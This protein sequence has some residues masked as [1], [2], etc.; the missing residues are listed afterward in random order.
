[1]AMWLDQI[2]EYKI[3]SDSEYAILLSPQF[4]VVL[5]NHTSRDFLLSEYT[6]EELTFDQCADLYTMLSQPDHL[7]VEPSARFTPAPNQIIDSDTFKLDIGAYSQQLKSVFSAET[8]DEKKKSLEALANNLFRS[9]PFLACKYSNLRTA[10]SEIDIVVQFLGF[11][12]STIFDEFGRYFLVECKNWNT[13]V[14]AAQVRDFIG[15]IQKTRVKLGIV[16]AKN[17]ISGERDGADAVREIH[18]AFDKDGL[19]VIVKSEKDLR[20]IEMGM[21]FYDILDQKINKLRFDL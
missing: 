1:M 7:P 16:F 12:K 8:N 11:D 10:S 9:I 13:S 2:K 15:K 3:V 14:G 18:T 17:G 5:Q 4:L 19:F 6:L 21:S 20:A